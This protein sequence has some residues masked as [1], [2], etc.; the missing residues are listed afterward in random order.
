MRLKLAVK[1]DLVRAMEAEY[2]RI[3]RAVTAAIDVVSADAQE[4]LR[5]QVEAAFGMRAGRR[6]AKT[7]RRKRYPRGSSVGAAALIYSRA[8]DIIR[9]SDSGAV[10]L[11][12]HGRFLA[13]PTNFNR[14]LGRRGTRSERATGGWAGVRVT[15]E[16]M[17]K[18][19]LAFVR[20]TSQGT[21]LIWFLKV[22][23]AQKQQG[24]RGKVRDLAYAGGLV[25]VGGGR[26][27]RT[28][29]ILEAGAVPMFYL[30]PQVRVPKRLSIA[31]IRSKAE[32]RLPRQIRHN[33]E[34]FPAEE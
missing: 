15:P 21:G 24:K 19:K 30:V 28:R 33:L 1:G 2:G 31:R 12:K 4:E 32:R 13:I 34:T 17:V 7:I 20:P 3:A 22:S 6:L 23:R 29:D 26:V 18:S 27:R 5:A 25:L 8:P 14:N 16:E 10:I 11:P 9:G